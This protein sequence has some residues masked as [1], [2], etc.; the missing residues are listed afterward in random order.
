MI[1]IKD[2]NPVKNKSYIRL[3]IL[4]I[5]TLIFLLQ[6]FT[7]LNYFLIMFYGFKPYSLIH[8]QILKLLTPYLQCLHQCFFMVV[9]FIS[10]EICYICGFLQIMLRMY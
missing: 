9:G 8:P 7:D 2:E 10:W 5:C 6:T 1:P 4:L 3:V